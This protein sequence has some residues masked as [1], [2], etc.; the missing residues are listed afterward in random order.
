MAVLKRGKFW[1]YEFMIDGRR[2]RG[3]TKETTQ[4]KAKHVESLIIAEVRNSGA[5]PNYKRAP[6]LDEFAL[7]FL[8][9]VDAQVSAGQL[10]HD[11]RRYYRVGWNLLS[12]TAIAAM[13]IDRIGTSDAAVLN[14]GRSPS[15]ANQAFRTLRRMLNMAVEWKVLRVAPKIKTL[16]EHGRTALIESGTEDLILR[17]AEHPLCDI[18]VIMMDCG[19]RPEEAMRMRWEHIQWDRDRILIPYGKSFK[20]KRQVPISA[21]IRSL[22]VRQQERAEK[23]RHVWCERRHVSEWDLAAWVFPS[24]RSVTGHLVTVAKQWREAVASANRELSGN[25]QPAL[26]PSLKLY[27]ARHTFATDMIA[28]GVNVVELRELLGHEDLKT[29]MKYVHS[30]IDNAAGAISRRNEAKKPFLVRGA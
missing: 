20:S 19:M 24:P 4:S 15:H 25:G 28:H 9:Y 7:R 2:Y 10:D 16:E 26:S 27:C 12:N 23:M 18:L 3:S 17:H 13:R 22:L 21:R 1:H 14:F 30:G 6:F 5:D 8:A 11:T 29:T